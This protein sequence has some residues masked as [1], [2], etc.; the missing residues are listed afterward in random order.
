M[1]SFSR[2]VPV[3]GGILAHSKFLGT[4]LTVVRGVPHHMSRAELVQAALLGC[5]DGKCCSSQ[6]APL[7]VEEEAVEGN[8]EAEVSLLS[9]SRPLSSLPTFRYHNF[10]FFPFPP[11]VSRKR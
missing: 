8:L 4:L 1:L 5:L 9:L 6:G 10:F 7:R 3:L 2:N 11:R